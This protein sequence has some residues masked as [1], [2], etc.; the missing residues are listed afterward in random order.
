MSYLPPDREAE[1][2]VA[3]AGIAMAAAK[4]LVRC[5]VAIRTA[6]GAIADGLREI[7]A[8]CLA[9]ADTSRTQL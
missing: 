3:E 1:V 6:D 8:A 2:I 9:D 5:A 7:A 4:R